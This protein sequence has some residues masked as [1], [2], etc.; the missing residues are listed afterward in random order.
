[1]RVL[2]AALAAVAALVTACG[3]GAS[4]AEP[5]AVSTPTA[6]DAPSEAATPAA[7]FPLTLTGSDGVSVTLD[8]PA[9]A[10]I[11]HS[12]GAT[13]ILFAIG[14][15]EQVVAVDDFSDYPPEAV[16]LQQVGYSDPNP[17]AEL[18]LEPDLVI[19]ASQQR[20]HVEPFRALDLP[21]LYLEAAPDIE[22]V[23]TNIRVLGQATGHTAEAEALVDD[24][25]ARIDAVVEQVAGVEEGPRVYY[26]LSDSLYT[27]APHTFIGSVLS[28]LKAQNIAEGATSQFP[29]LGSEAVIAADPEVILLANAVHGVTYESVRDRPGWDAISA[30]VDE[31]V[32]AVDQ[33]IMNRP[34]PRIVEGVET[35]ARALYPDIFE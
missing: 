4:V 32:I 16:A 26:E 6:V 12:P 34:G 25:R 14:A 10:V 15:G 7:V 1:M 27:A 29:Q 3:G 21:V 28:T 23:F 22:G 5:P 2:F 35:L 8:A 17:E 31:R 33:D 18:A 11:S 30:V 19:L 20:A 24:M 13:E 9:S